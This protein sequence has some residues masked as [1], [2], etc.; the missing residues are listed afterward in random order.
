MF[1]LLIEPLLGMSIISE[2]FIATDGVPCPC[3]LTAATV[4]LYSA[5]W[6]MMRTLKLAFWLPAETGTDS[7]NC[8]LLPRK[9]NKMS[10]YV[11]IG[12]WYRDLSRPLD[13]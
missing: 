12:T 5:G 6:S 8:T 2:M 11:D 1:I 10:Q 9:Q 7:F 4:T 13:N 3:S